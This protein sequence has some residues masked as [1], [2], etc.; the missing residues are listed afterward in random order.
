MTDHY[1]RPEAGIHAVQIEI[2]RSIYMDE[3]RIERGSHLPRLSEQMA[4]VVD[5]LG[6]VRLPPRRR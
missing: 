5:A 2:N 6:D 1:G 4:A 3:R